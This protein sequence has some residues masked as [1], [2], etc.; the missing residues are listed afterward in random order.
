MDSC[1]SL[2]HEV[3]QHHEGIT[4][5]LVSKPQRRAHAPLSGGLEGIDQN[6]YTKVGAISTT[7]LQ[8]PNNTTKLLQH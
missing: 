1:S 4:L 7:Q 8:D 3:N 6:L 2:L 5:S